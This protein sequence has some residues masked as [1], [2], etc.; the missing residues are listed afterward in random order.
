MKRII[1]GF[2]GILMIAGCSD[3]SKTDTPDPEQPNPDPEITEVTV[4]EKPE[5]KTLILSG[6]VKDPQGN[7]LAGVTVTTGNVTMQTNLAGAFRLDQVGVVSQRTVIHFSKEGYF[8]ITRSLEQ[9][10]EDIWEIIMYPKG[11]SD[12]STSATFTSTNATKLQIG[13]MKIDMPQNGYRIE[14]SNKSYTGNVTA[15]IIY[16]DPNNPAF[17]AAMPG[18]DL[19]AV[20]QDNS[21]V[22]LVSYGIVGVNLSSGDGQQLQL[23]DGKTATLTY[24]IPEGMDNNLPKSIPLWYFNEKAGLWIEA[25]IA[26]RVGNEYT[27]EVK[28]FSYYNLDDPK[29]RAK[30][31][32]KVMDCKNRPVIGKKVIINHSPGI[33]DAQGFYSITVPSGTS[34][35]AT[36]RSEDYGYYKNVVSHTIPALDAETTYTQNFQLPCLS[37]ISGQIVNTCES[38]SASLVWLEYN[39]IIYE[40]TYTKTNGLFSIS[41]PEDYTGPAT[42]KIRTS[43]EN[44]ISIDLRLDNK[45]LNIGIINVC[46]ENAIGGIFIFTFPNGSTRTYEFN[47]SQMEGVIRLNGNTL[48]I[49]S[50][51]VYLEIPD[52]SPEQSQYSNVSVA[53]LD[54]N[55]NPIMIGEMNVDVNFIPEKGIYQFDITGKGNT[56]Y[57][58]QPGDVK[59]RINVYLVIDMV[60]HQNVTSIQDINLPSFAP[61]VPTPID[62]VS[63]VN[64]KIGKGVLLDYKNP[65]VEVFNQIKG[66]ADLLGFDVLWFDDGEDS[67]EICYQQGDKVIQLSY[68]AQGFTLIGIP[69]DE[70]YYFEIMILDDCKIDFEEG[71]S[72]HS[73]KMILKQWG[74]INRTSQLH[75]KEKQ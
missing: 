51:N 42:L 38:N 31:E 25:G 10:N 26:Q 55:G 2:L 35:T 19:I 40:E 75:K 59:G 14:S 54:D 58:P 4:N 52:Y 28:H 39:G 13:K 74:H 32:G 15:D 56:T 71:R 12:L 44:T 7:Q 21:N 23:A 65:D 62:L 47:P 24:P 43:S 36:V 37:S 50:E 11:E 67:K 6:F 17:S 68:D 70:D 48:M 22:S 41:S 64:G 29:R 27:G 73:N 69:D 1:I 16:L 53:I 5:M 3:N 46:E 61:T 49:S 60:N 9:A 30:V 63:Y 18:G 20:R 33:T 66:Q 8:N 45:D 34:M 72:V 57:N